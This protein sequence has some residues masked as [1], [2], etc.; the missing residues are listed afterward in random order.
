MGIFSNLLEMILSFFM[1]KDVPEVK[2]LPKMEENQVPQ[3][4][5]VDWSNP[6]CKVS[7]YFTVNEMLYLPT[8]K[9]LANEGDGLDDEIKANLI[10]LAQKMDTVREYF[11][12][13]INVHVTYRPTEYNKAIG[14]AL[15]SAHSEGKACDFHVMGMTCDEIRDEIVAKGL[16]DLWEMRCEKKPGSNW[17]HLDYRELKTGGNR[18]FIP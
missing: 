9:R 15:R 6:A 1:K 2:E 8:W 7:K 10:G 3:E 18:Y 12:K 4:A 13:P 14:G 11:D 17:V 16:L 5:V